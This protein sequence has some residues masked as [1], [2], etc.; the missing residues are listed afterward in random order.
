MIQRATVI[1]IG[2]ADR[3]D[4][5]VGLHVARRVAAE[6]PDLRVVE[7][8]DPSE[9]LAVWTPEEVVVVVDAFTSGGDPGDIQVF[10]AVART[11]PT[12]SWASGGT[13]A[14]GIAAVVELGRALGRLPRR[15]LVVGVEGGRFDRGTPMSDPVAAAVP[16][17]ARAVLGAVAGG[18]GGH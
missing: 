13:H 17:A 14:F 8:A 5:A 1:G 7:L 12:G 16:A 10:D 15:L 11:L 18:Q 4:D 9:A 3:G 6:N 2:N